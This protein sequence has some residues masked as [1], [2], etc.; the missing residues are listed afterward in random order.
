MPYYAES[1]KPRNKYNDLL[2]EDE[3]KLLPSIIDLALDRN[4]GARV[5]L[6]KVNSTN[7]HKLS[8]QIENPLTDT[9]MSF[10]LVDPNMKESKK[11]RSKTKYPS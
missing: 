6:S 9:K 3:V 2:S 11:T 10:L 4:N 1:E 7:S 8:V 5:E